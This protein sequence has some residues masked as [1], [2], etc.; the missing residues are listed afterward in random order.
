M[1]SSSD[2]AAG[3]GGGAITGAGVHAPV[4]PRTRGVTIADIAITLLLT[5]LII[6]GFP[7][8]AAVLREFGA[9]PANFLLLIA[10]GILLARR[11][12][13]GRAMGVTVQE[14]YLLV[15]ILVGA[16]LLNLPIALMQSPVGAREALTD[17]M[18]QF[19]ML[20]WGVTSYCI[21]KRVVAGMH[22]RRYCALMAL[23]AVLPV[24][25][26]IPDYFDHSGPVTAVLDLFRLG[27]NGRASSFATEPSIYGAWVA[28]IWPLVLFYTM[29]GGH[30]LGRLAGRA[31]LVAAFLTAL[32]SNARTFAVVLMLQLV[33]GCYWSIQ[34]QRGWGSRVRSLLL[35]LCITVAAATA[36]ASRLMTTTDLVR[37][38]SDI[39]RIGDTVTGINVSVAHPLV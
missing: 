11:I 21:W 31:L 14:S 27:R 30:A 38:E 5:S 12:M 9:R 16:P 39:T 10:W 28:I 17:W 24:L 19:L 34:K 22:P 33:Y 2:L 29:R 1:S 15:A 26:F 25:A 32:I 23:S 7:A 20:G 3:A 35:A 36:L 4:L 13:R 8:G 6:D 37:N 18:K